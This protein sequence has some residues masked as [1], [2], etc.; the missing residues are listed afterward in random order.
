MKQTLIAVS[1][2]VL[3]AGCGGK[4]EPAQVGFVPVGMAAGIGDCVDP[5]APTAR[6]WAMGVDDDGDVLVCRDD[7][8]ECR[9]VDL[10]TGAMSEHYPKI[11]GA[12]YDKPGAVVQD[13]GQL[14][15]CW[16]QT[17]CQRRTPAAY[18]KW[19]QAI[20]HADRVAVLS[21][22][23]DK[24]YVTT[25]DHD[26]TTVLRFEVAP[27][28]ADVV[29]RDDR[30]LI[31]A[32]ENGE[33]HGYLY[34][35]KGHVVGV[36][37]AVGGAPALDIGPGPVDLAPSGWAFLAN[38]A[39]VVA[40]HDFAGGTPARIDVGAAQPA[41]LSDLASAGEG[42]LAVALGGARYG[43]VLIVDVDAKAV[44]PLPGKRCEAP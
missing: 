13:D 40:V 3:G 15:V 36:V 44:K 6:A 26:L 17:S 23:S 29:W 4:S 35:A 21:S 14:L 11:E 19:M 9:A 34:D 18:E 8:E 22:E 41:G 43:D 12:E 33:T 2:L 30:F 10:S 38:D 7:A 39:T 27:A 42:R 37:G 31:H 24:K 16:G 1:L 25:M 32:H 28:A 20:V 5:P